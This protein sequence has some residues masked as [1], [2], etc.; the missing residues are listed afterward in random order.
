MSRKQAKEAMEGADRPPKR[1]KLSPEHDSEQK[2]TG[3][4]STL[5]G[6]QSTVAGA[7][8]PPIG[9]NEDTSDEDPDEVITSSGGPA[10]ASDLYLDTVCIRSFHSVKL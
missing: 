4:E 8:I 10:R 7:A 6:G 1:A 9:Q 5:V 2:V 3:R